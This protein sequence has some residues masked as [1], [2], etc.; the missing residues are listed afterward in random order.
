V[1]H[2]ISLIVTCLLLAGLIF[3]PL[4]RS[5]D[6]FVAP[7][8]NDGAACS[9]AAP[10]KSFDRAYK[11]AAPGDVVEVA[12]GDY[13]SQ[14][15]SA[16]DK[17]SADVVHFVPAAGARPHLADLVIFASHIE[18]AGVKSDGGWYVKPGADDV[19]LRDIEASTWYAVRDASNVRIL[20]G[21]VGP[22]LNTTPQVTG[23]TNVTF[24]GVLFHDWTRNDSS[25]HVDCMGVFGNTTNVTVR[26]SQFR[27]CEA[28]DI[29]FDQSVVDAPNR[30]VLVENNFFSCCRSGY[31]S[32]MFSQHDGDAV[33]RHNS[34]DTSMA[35]D[36]EKIGSG[37]VL[38]D[39]NI[40]PSI[41]SF[42]CTHAT[43]KYN[44]VAGGGTCAATN[45]K[46]SALFVDPG[47]F[48]FHLRPGSAA[49][50]AANPA[51]GPSAD[52]DGGGRVRAP[53]VGAD[54]YGSTAASNPPTSPAPP[55]QPPAPIA[56]VVAPITKSGSS[57]DSSKGSSASVNR[58]LIVDGRQL[59]GVFGK[60]AMIA[61]RCVRRCR[62]QA[63]LSLSSA[64]AKRLHVG[65]VLAAAAGSRNSAGLVHLR[66]RASK[67][68][69]A[70][71]AKRHGLKLFATAVV[72]S[73]SGSRLVLRRT[74]VVQ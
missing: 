73:A 69:R 1:S 55:V 61:V 39:S 40:L 15:I 27:N 48:D 18:V 21:S 49:I 32:V 33:V 41:S 58:R 72:R 12:G 66:L 28:F 7:A 46:G 68:A 64:T 44:L 20:G 29:L 4:A 38:F 35:M 26:N 65:R 11:A 5:T 3:T 34:A 43:W 63:R 24:D 67:S 52:I 37:T 45:K 23:S 60:G 9:Q 6:R 59:R 42:D 31:Y 14:S 54:E 8:G 16:E 74:F 51:Q 57:S 30:G 56:N 25:S 50:D 71:L 53:D 17:A 13:G 22:G 10:C 19:T 36:T 70:K 2:R 62:V 47:A